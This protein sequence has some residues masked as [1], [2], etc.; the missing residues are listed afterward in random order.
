MNI[1]KEPGKPGFSFNGSFLLELNASYTYSSFSATN[2]Q[3]FNVELVVSLDVS[4]SCCHCTVTSNA[5]CSSNWSYSQRCNVYSCCVSKRYRSGCSVSNNFSTVLICY[6]NVV[7][8]AIN[9]ASCIEC[10][11][12]SKV[13]S[14]FRSTVYVWSTWSYNTSYKFHGSNFISSF[15]ECHV[16]SQFLT[17]FVNQ[18]CYW[19]YKLR[20]VPVCS[21]SNSYIKCAISNICIYC[22]IRV[23]RYF[24]ICSWQLNFRTICKY[25]IYFN[26]FVVCIYISFSSC[27]FIVYRTNCIYRVGSILS[28]VSYSNSCFTSAGNKRACFSCD[29]E[30]KLL[31]TFCSTNVN[32]SANYCWSSCAIRFNLERCNWCCRCC[33]VWNIDCCI[34]LIFSYCNFTSCVCKQPCRNVS[35]A[36]YTSILVLNYQVS[37]IDCCIC[38]D[39]QTSCCKVAIQ[40]TNYCRYSFSCYVQVHSFNLVSRCHCNDW[41]QTS[42]S[43]LASWNLDLNNIVFQYERIVDCRTVNSDFNTFISAVQGADACDCCSG[44]VKHFNWYICIFVNIYNTWV[45]QVN[46]VRTKCFCRCYSEGSIFTR[47]VRDQSDYGL[48][49]T[50]VCCRCSRVVQTQC[51]FASAFHINSSECCCSVNDCRISLVDDQIICKLRCVS[52]SITILV[53][54]VYQKV[55]CVSCKICVFVKRFVVFVVKT[56]NFNFSNTSLCNNCECFNSGSCCFCM[57]KCYCKHIIDSVCTIDFNCTSSRV[58]STDVVAQ[59]SELSDILTILVQY[60]VRDRQIV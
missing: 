16:L 32:G 10:S 4:Y 31:S 8:R 7:Y 17:S 18:N 54:S 22:A 2:V 41:F 56:S 50:S 34:R 58:Q 55:E 20:I 52:N 45:V 37:M 36:H 46:C 26:Y 60:L 29:S 47:S 25:T 28:T 21:Q 13:V 57:Y 42:R 51:S 12:N 15:R 14:C 38:S 23:S 35:I 39:V 44:F 59:G 33:R 1:K 19:H 24:V 30:G 40:T 43:K 49:L 48:T 27:C 9:Q 11:A 6:N 53:F 3:D 5:D